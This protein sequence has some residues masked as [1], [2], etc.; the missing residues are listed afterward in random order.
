MSDTVIDYANVLC[1][2]KSLVTHLAHSMYHPPILFCDQK[3]C[4]RVIFCVYIVTA[5]PFLGLLYQ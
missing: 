1:A 4:E 5:H 3:L 2:M